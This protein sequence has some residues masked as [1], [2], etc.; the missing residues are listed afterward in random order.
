MFDTESKRHLK[1]DPALALPV[2]G[3]AFPLK[4]KAVGNEEEEVFIGRDAVAD[5]WTF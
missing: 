1:N 4:R 2:E 3:V 5:L